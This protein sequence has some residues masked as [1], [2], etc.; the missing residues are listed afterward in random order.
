M[1]F[2]ASLGDS[3]AVSTMIGAFMPLATALG[4]AM[5]TWLSATHSYSLVGNLAASGI[6]V[7]CFIF[8]SAQLRNRTA[9]SK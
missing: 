6:G 2:S 1:G 9:V 7:T 3:G 5:S 4:P 8:V